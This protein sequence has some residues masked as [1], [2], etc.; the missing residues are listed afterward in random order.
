MAL[1]SG[2]GARFALAAVL[3]ATALLRLRLLAVPLERDEG[4][5]AYL[6]QLILR[7]EVPYVAAHNMKLPGVYYAYAAILAAFGETGVAIH[8]GLIIINLASVILLFQLGRVLLDEWAGLGAAI[9]YAVLSLSA[10]VSGFSANAEHFVV[11]PMLGGVLLLA[12]ARAAAR[13]ARIVG[14]GLLL[15]IAFLMK[16]H[17]A[18]FVAF[19][20]L[21][22][23]ITR[24]RRAGWTAAAREGG[25][26]AI[27]ALAPFGLT[28]LTM[29][30]SGAF[31]PFWFWSMTYAREYATMIPIDVGLAELAMQVA[32]ITGSSIALWLLVLVGTTALWWDDASRRAAPFLGSFAVASVAAVSTGLRFT[33]HYF[34]L[35]L[36]AASLLAGVAASSLVRLAVTGRPGREALVGVGIPLVAA[37]LSIAQERAYLFAMSPVAVSRA[38]NGSNPFPEAIEIARYVRERSRPDDRVAVIGSEP[39]I[40]FYAQ[41]PAATSYIYTYP[42]MEPHPFADQ[43]QEDMIA[44]IERAQPRFMI[45]VNVDTSWSRRSDSS[46]RLLDWSAKTVD[47][48]YRVVGLADIALDGGTVYRWDDDAR[49]ARPG[50]RSYVVTFERRR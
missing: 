4:E 22:V 37:L 46:T 50:S 33:D 41:R 30:M 18:A 32:T 35:L 39:E 7:G 1:I 29:Y 47:E 23:L 43:M 16:Q 28:C 25:L 21:W 31:A 5:Y 10:S 42:L 19:G 44:Q 40:Y 45:L 8:V 27:A 13:P 48:H 11:L 34:I 36:P 15:G 6:G 17:A 49:D 20:G 24:V 3:A 9:T 14:A 12:P 26:F 2:R 38:V